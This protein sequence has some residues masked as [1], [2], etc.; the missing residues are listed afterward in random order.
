VA[1]QMDE[2]R[3]GRRW[4]TL[5]DTAT[6]ETAFADAPAAWNANRRGSD[7]YNEMLLVWLEADTAIRRMTGDKRSLDDFCARF[8]AGP[9]REPTV[10]PYSRV[11][12]IASL[13]TVAPMDW[14]TFVSAKLDAINPRAPLDGLVASGWTLTYDD[15]PNTFLEAVEKRSATYDF[16]TSLGLWVKSDGTVQD[17]IPG[18]PAFITGVAPGMRI[19]TIDGRNWT[20]EAAHNALRQAE[21]RPDPIVLK[22]AFGNTVRFARVNYHGGFRY[23]RLVRSPEKPDLLDEILAPRGNNASPRSPTK[24]R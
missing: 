10:K 3:P 24:D 6:A 17:A 23:P 7:Y 8:F 1:A 9:E 20:I 19:L 13:N 14:G 5:G 2:E 18:S 4:R 12:V 15:T 11:D 22:I 21:T 16:G